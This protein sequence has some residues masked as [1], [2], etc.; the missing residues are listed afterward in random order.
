MFAKN[1]DGLAEQ[2]SKY[3]EQ[4]GGEMLVSRLW[5]ERKL[6]YPI[7][8]H[9]RGTYWLTYFKLDTQQV[10]EL[11][12]ECQIADFI[13]RFLFLQVDPRLVDTLVEHALAGP[14]RPESDIVVEVEDELE[15]VEFE[16]TVEDGIEVVV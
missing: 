12:H 10:S 7:K 13:L 15:V 1:A 6:A 4:A 8:G 5:E 14:I 2:I 16:E 11:N 9:R 3:I